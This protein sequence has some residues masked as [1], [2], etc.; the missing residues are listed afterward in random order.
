MTKQSLT[1][2]LNGL[3]PDKPYVTF[4]DIHRVAS[5][6]ET[7]V[8]AVLAALKIDR[9][10]GYFTFHDV[11]R[12]AELAI[13]GLPVTSHETEILGRQIDPAQSPVVRDVPVYL[14]DRYAPE[15]SEGVA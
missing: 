9:T 15:I 10:R 2:A 5:L 7:G 14:L 4:H 3:T 11:Q 6:G 12:A 1:E 13:N 8:D